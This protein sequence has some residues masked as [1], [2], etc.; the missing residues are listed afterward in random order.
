MRARRS[1]KA[2]P[3]HAIATLNVM[4]TTAGAPSGAEVDRLLEATAAALG[5]CID[6]TGCIARW[7]AGNWLENAALA[8]KAA[9]R[10]GD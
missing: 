7:S 2:L 5:A 3:L 4:A 1:H 9:S 10:E 8:D 6:G